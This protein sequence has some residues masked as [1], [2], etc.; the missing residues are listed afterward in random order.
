METYLRCF[1]SEKPKTWATYLAWAELNYNSAFHSAL[2]MTQFRALYG[3]D[4]PTWIKFETGSTTN[5]ELE[6]QLR[7]RDALLTLLRENLHRAQQMMND[8]ADKHRREI[9]FAVGDWVYVKLRPYRQ[10]TLARRLNEKLSARYYGPFEVEARVGQVAYKVKLPAGAKIH[11]TFHVSQLKKAVGET[12]DSLP[13]PH[14]LNSEGELVVE[15]AGVL[16][17]RIHGGTG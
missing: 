13:F 8:R 2:K 5:A 4:P 15:P 6:G 11:P 1:A 7:D 12:G 10:K 16:S 3:R 14:Q 17:S 9:T